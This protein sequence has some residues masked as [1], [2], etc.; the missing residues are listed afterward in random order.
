MD[1]RG[2]VMVLIVGSSR[3]KKT[4]T[5]VLGD[6]GYIAPFPSLIKTNPRTS[7]CIT[8]NGVQYLFDIYPEVP[9]DLQAYH[10]ILFVIN[11]P[12]SGPYEY[13]SFEYLNNLF[14]TLGPEN[15]HKLYL[16]WTFAEG[17]SSQEKKS[18]LEQM[19]QLDTP[20]QWLARNNHV[21]F[22]GCVTV[23]DYAESVPRIT[24]NVEE[25]VGQ[26]WG[27]LAN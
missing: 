17:V 2:D 1:G 15:R 24:R 14:N 23:G 19:P 6:Q 20:C 8:R 16:V 4:I 18:V 25:M 27:V 3:G 26:M 9:N 5:H 13:S 21:L 11:L 22:T 10:K 7:T 12:N